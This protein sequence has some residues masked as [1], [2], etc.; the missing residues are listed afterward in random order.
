MSENG[1]RT[2]VVTKNADV[3][4]QMETLLKQATGSFSVT[5]S[6][7]ARDAASQCKSAPP[8]CILYDN[9]N[10]EDGAAFIQILEQECGQVPAPVVTLLP[11]E[12]KQVLAKLIKAGV[13]DYLLL[14]DLQPDTV[15]RT[16]RYALERRVLEKR[17]SEQRNLFKAVLGGSPGFI[18]IK[19]E[20]LQYQAVNPAFCAFLGKGLDEIVG[21]TDDS[22]FGK[23][24]AELYK[25]DDSH[26]L[27]SGIPQTKRVEMT[28]VEGARWLEVL[29][30]PIIDSKGEVAGVF[31]AGH[32][33]TAAIELEAQVDELKGTLDSVS[34]D[35]SE[36]LCRV[37]AK[38]VLTYVNSAVCRAF[39][40]T[41]D[42]LVGQ[43]FSTL[44]PKEAQT[45]VRNLLASLKPDNPAGTHRQKVNVGGEER[46]QEW[47]TRAMYGDN[48]KLDEFVSVGH[49]I[50]ALVRAEE[51]AAEAR[52]ERDAKAGEIDA[53]A[54]ARQAA[55]D[56]A[57][58]QKG[59][60]EEKEA[61]LAQAQQE[62]DAAVKER[63]DARKAAE[64][65]A[66]AQKG[67][68]EEKEAALVQAQQERDVIVKERDAAAKERDDVRQALAEVQQQLDQKN[69]E[70]QG[71]QERIGALE[72]QNNELQQKAAQ[73]EQAV[74]EKEDALGGVQQEVAS[75]D[76]ALREKEAAVADLERRLQES[77]QLLKAGEAALAESEAEAKKIK[78]QADQ[79]AAE[80]GHVGQRLEDVYALVP[81]GVFELAAGTKVTFMSQGACDILGCKPEEAESG[82]LVLL[83][84]FDA[85]DKKAAT[86]CMKESMQHRRRTS[87]EYRVARRDGSSVDVI[88]TAA[89]IVRD[90]KIQ[91]MLV[92]LTDVSAGKQAGLMLESIRRLADTAATTAGMLTGVARLT[93]GLVQ[94]GE[95]ALDAGKL[96]ALEK[97]AESARQVLEELLTQ[98]P[99]K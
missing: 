76:A 83:D 2:L 50:T 12:K 53:L 64:E 58:A 1:I 51:A 38:G 49:D 71:I 73:L 21:K 81:T 56:A 25:K 98:K 30:T 7:S 69:Q 19:N 95:T 80:L 99:S 43:G 29:R 9:G 61:A 72:A 79:A 68:L 75:R 44:I 45:E 4:A 34:V 22:I 11:D 6:E 54:K 52:A 60:I 46:W 89:P 5:R 36:M 90:D 39:G 87:G 77:D 66:A 42:E 24:D 55:E 84:F 33:V 65:A 41:Q 17:L 37:A 97:A 86:E 13:T 62:R 82:N 57:A 92:A 85:K 10:D 20:Q 70:L 35:Q 8:D 67:A 16:M 28:G 94:N 93:S 15:S 88:L 96:D 63:D 74:K 47:T 40:K 26:V 32:D 91:G 59:A 27:K 78:E 48:G 18:A 31:F 3:A 23:K 14:P